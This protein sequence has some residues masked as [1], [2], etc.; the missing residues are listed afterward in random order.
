MS[1]DHKTITGP[2]V[3]LPFPYISTSDPGAVGAGLW[4]ADLTNQIIK[5]RNAGDTGWDSFGGSGGGGFTP[6][7][8]WP[9]AVQDIPPVSPSANDDEFTTSA[10]LPGGGSAIWTWRNQGT[11]ALTIANSL[12]DF[13]IQNTTGNNVRII[14]QTIPSGNFTVTTKLASRVYP[15]SATGGST[16]KGFG[17]GFGAGLC[18]IE[19]GSGK[20]GFLELV[21]DST[22]RCY[23]QHWN[24]VTSFAATTGFADSLMQQQYYYLR[25]Q[26]ASTTLTYS[27]SYDGIF[28]MPFYA[29]AVASFFTPDRFGLHV[30]GISV[31]G[32]L[33]SDYFRYTSP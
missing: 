14:E 16:G 18:L 1:V 6:N 27:V 32:H 22:W 2:D 9:Q 17:Q 8:G 7:S 28:W 19:S 23:S 29:E 26:R 20:I 30:F 24:S 3:H 33:V 5:R 21:F 4:W 11:S 25:I 31:N 15:N 10:S 12:L 13:A